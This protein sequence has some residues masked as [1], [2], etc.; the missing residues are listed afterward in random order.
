MTDEELDQKISEAEARVVQEE[1]NIKNGNVVHPGR[2]WELE[3]ERQRLRNVSCERESCRL[4]DYRSMLFDVADRVES[5]PEHWSVWP[6]A[7]PGKVLSTYFPHGM[8]AENRK[9][10]AAYLR[11]AA[12]KTWVT[13]SNPLSLMA[14]PG[15]GGSTQYTFLV[16]EHEGLDG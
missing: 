10:V 5:G 11:E 4:F 9:I 12:S 3:K 2:W 15:P 13:C 16:Y 7:V 6:M 14:S 1:Q 8:E